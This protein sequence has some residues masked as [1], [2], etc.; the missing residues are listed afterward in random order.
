MNSYNINLAENGMVSHRHLAE[1][2]LEHYAL[3]GAGLTLLSDTGTAIYRV[4]ISSEQGALYHPYLG[5]VDGQQMLLRIEGADDGRM[6][7]TYSELTLLAALLRDTDLALP[8][9]VPTASGALV[10]EIWAEGS[11]IPH[12]CV[13]FRWAGR[14]FPGAAMSRVAHFYEN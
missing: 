2:A 12:Q 13:L 11:A 6:S 8:E 4:T 7:T 3:Q 10:P 9:P 14:S 5:R 1:I